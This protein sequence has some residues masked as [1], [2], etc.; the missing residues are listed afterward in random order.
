M[1]KVLLT[2]LVAGMLALATLFAAPAEAQCNST[3]SPWGGQTV[4]TYPDGSTTTCGWWQ[5]WGFGGTNGDCY[6]Y[7][8]YSYNPYQG[9]AFGYPP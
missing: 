2:L 9:P 1:R 5:F 8:N 6:G 4:C 3:W 7:G